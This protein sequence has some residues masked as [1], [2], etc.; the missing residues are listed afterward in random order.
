MVSAAGPDGRPDW[1]PP[2]GRESAGGRARGFALLLALA[3]LLI[4]AIVLALA[5]RAAYG[6]KNAM[7]RERRLIELRAASD[8]ALA[9][10]LAAL[11][12]RSSF[13]GFAVHRFGRAALSSSVTGMGSRRRRVE[14]TAVEDGWRMTLTATVRIDDDGKVWI[15]TWDRSP[16][17]PARG[18]SVSE[19]E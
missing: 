7:Q 6:S 11:E 15:E 19:L 4:V 13:S 8:A 12:E 14:A 10:T 16:A 2:D 1:F 3:I 17:R 9:E 5:F 18:G